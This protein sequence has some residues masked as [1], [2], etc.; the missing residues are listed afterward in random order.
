M[1]DEALGKWCHACRSYGCNGINIATSTHLFSEQLTSLRNDM[2]H[3]H[4]VDPDQVSP[5]QLLILNEAIFITAAAGKISEGSFVYRDVMSDKLRLWHPMPYHF[6]PKA[7]T[8]GYMNSAACGE[9]HKGDITSIYVYIDGGYK[10]AE[11]E[12]DHIDTHTWGFCC[13]VEE[14]N[15]IQKLI[16]CTSGPIVFETS[17]E[18]HIE[19]MP[20]NSSFVTELFEQ[21]MARIFFLQHL[22]EYVDC[23]SIYVEIVY[24]NK[25]ANALATTSKASEKQS[26]LTSLCQALDIAVNKIYPYTSSGHIKSHLLHPWN[27]LADELDRFVR[28]NDFCCYY[29]SCSY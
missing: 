28:N 15:G 29:G 10:E 23:N 16:C 18:N 5:H 13:I 19:Q 3:S 2:F 12:Y 8:T 25:G 14:Y 17:Y 7:C 21:A 6:R 22:H 4:D 9:A 24:D 11:S 1:L 27:E 26:D 20:D